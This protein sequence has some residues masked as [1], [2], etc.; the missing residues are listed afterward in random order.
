M[1]NNNSVMGRPR[2]PDYTKKQLRFS[3]VEREF[4]NVI[5]KIDNPLTREMILAALDNL[6]K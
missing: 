5:E 3:K 1:A 4:N 2:T 6:K